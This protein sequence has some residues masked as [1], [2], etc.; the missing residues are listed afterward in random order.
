MDGFLPHA[1]EFPLHFR[2]HRPVGAEETE[3][4]L[5]AATIGQFGGASQ[6]HGERIFAAVLRTQSPD[7]L[8][9]FGKPLTDVLSGRVEMLDGIFS[10]VVAQKL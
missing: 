2:R 7:R 6:F 3:R 8:T 9:C 4:R 1:Q 5:N 10:V